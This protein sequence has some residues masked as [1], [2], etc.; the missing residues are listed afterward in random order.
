M[1]RKTVHISLLVTVFMKYRILKKYTI[2]RRT[3]CFQHCPHRDSKPPAVVSWSPSSTNF[4][5]NMLS[6]STLGEAAARICMKIEIVCLH[7]GHM[8]FADNNYLLLKR[9]TMHHKTEFA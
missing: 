2:L 9:I 8:L 3:F 6:P 4:H 5:T 1:A 7:V